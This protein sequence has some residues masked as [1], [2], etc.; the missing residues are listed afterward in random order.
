QKIYMSHTTESNFSSG[1]KPD[2]SNMTLVYDGSITWESGWT[3]ITLST[4]F[5]Y[6]NVDNLLIYYENRAGSYTSDY[7][8]WYYTSK[9]NRAAYKRYDWGFPTGDGTVCDLVPNVRLYPPP[10]LEVEKKVYNGTA[11]VDEITDAELNNTY[12]FRINITSNCCDFANVTVNDTLSSSLTYAG[13]AIP[14]EPASLGGNKYQWTFPTLNKGQTITIEFDAV[15]SSYGYDCNVANVTANCT[16]DGVIYSVNDTACLNIV[17]PA[18]RFDEVWNNTMD[19]NSNIFPL[20]DDVNDIATTNASAD[21]DSDGIPEIVA[22]DEDGNVTVYENTGDNSYTSVWQNDTSNIVGDWPYMLSVCVCDLDDNGRREIVTGDDIG[23]VLIFEWDGTSNNYTLVAQHDFGSGKIEDLCCDDMDGDGEQELGIAF[24]SSAYIYNVSSGWAWPWNQ[25]FG[26]NVGSQVFSLLCGCDLDNNG[27]E[28]FIFGAYNDNIFIYESTGPNTYT[29]RWNKQLSSWAYP[30]AMA[31][32]N[33][34]QDANGYQELYV[35]DSYG[36][37]FV[38]TNTGDLTACSDS[39]IHD[40]GDAINGMCCGNED[41]DTMNDLYLA[42]D[43]DN[44]HDLEFFGSDVTDYSHYKESII[45]HDLNPGYNNA[46]A[47]HCTDLDGDG[48]REV[49]AGYEGSSGDPMLFVLEHRMP[50]LDIQ[51]TVYDPVTGRWVDNRIS[52]TKGETY[53]FR[54][55]ITSNC[56]NF[57]NVTV[58]DTLSP[59]LEYANAATRPPSQQIGNFVQWTFDK[60]NKS[61]TKTIEFNATVIECGYDCNLANVTANCTDTGNWCSAEDTACIDTKCPDLI[62]DWGFILNYDCTSLSSE[63]TFFGPEPCPGARTQCNNISAR[64]KENAWVNVT[65]PFNVTFEVN[66]NEICSARIPNLT[67]GQYSPFIHCDCNFTPYA[68][69]RYNLSVTVDADNEIKETNENNNIGWKNRTAKVLGYKGDGWQDCRNITNVITPKRGHVE[70]Q[71]AVCDHVSWINETGTHYLPTGDTYLSIVGG[72]WPNYYLNNMTVYRG[73]WNKTMLP[74]PSGAT[75]KEARLY[76]YYTWSMHITG[77]WSSGYPYGYGT[78]P[79][80]N[81][82]FNGGANV[83]ID[84]V[85]GNYTD[86]KGFGSYDYPA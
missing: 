58:N 10:C 38:I 67:A 86:R 70:L 13:S 75:I 50:C 65:D 8:E 5:S 18:N 30:Y 3:V 64:V 25:E 7:P 85:D 76:V 6:N 21:L 49:I 74:I 59:S 54:I 71:Y 60:L 63:D 33:M 29:Q 2:P 51:K 31:C 35:G 68:G 16:D 23:N 45:G 46:E 37:L 66:G 62:V 41:N 73:E 56:C 55:S 69:I 15:A 26:Y 27:S 4:P 83:T 42:M 9:A 43:D 36:Q 48:K 61:E 24:S 81:M 22:V 47:V 1:V 78:Y 82:S 79:N 28:E 72:S 77:F 84:N 39:L 57:T 40:Y 34:D 17:P 32:C 19:P 80:F 53:R 52:G 11:W 12:R 44:V 14:S 20:T